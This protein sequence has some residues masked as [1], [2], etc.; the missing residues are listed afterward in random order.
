MKIRSPWAARYSV[1]SHQ[2]GWT[3]DD[4]EEEGLK[5]K[6]AVKKGRFLVNASK[7]DSCLEAKAP[8]VS[9]INW[10]IWRHERVS[11]MRVRGW[12]KRS[13]WLIRQI[14]LVRASCIVVD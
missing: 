8:M 7:M 2:T 9:K 4:K 6:A 12:G 3:R 14:V 5:L 13:F 10:R 1:N 11:R